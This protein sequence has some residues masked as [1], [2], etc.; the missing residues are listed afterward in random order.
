MEFLA[1]ADMLSAVEDAAFQFKN[2]A[3]FSCGDKYESFD[4]REKFSKGIGATF[5]VQ[6]DRFD[7]ILADEAQKQG[8]DIR[9]GQMVTAFN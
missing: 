5:Q 1:Q 3:D 7:K 9:Y 2:G 4:F 6:R 8:V